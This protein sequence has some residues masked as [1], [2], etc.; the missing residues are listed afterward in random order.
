MRIVDAF[1]EKRNLEVSCKEITFV[2]GDSQSDVENAIR[3][4]E[5][6]YMVVKIP[7]SQPEL[8]FVLPEWGF[9][10]VECIMSMEHNLKNISM[11]R[12]WERLNVDLHYCTMDETDMEVM[13]KEIYE[14]L[15]STDRICVDPHFTK[16]VASNRYVN[17]IKDE[18]KLKCQLYK[19]MFKDK[20]IG[21]FTFKETQP[22]IYFPFLAGLYSAYL[23][24]GLGFSINLKALEEAKARNGKKVYG[25]IST[26]NAAIIKIQYTLGYSITNMHYV[27]V[28]HRK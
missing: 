7:T 5:A 8:T 3:D 15:F 9:S 10:F 14:G 27:Y 20:N 2:L 17:W 25:F 28:K 24:S 18:M 1:W 23:N 22:G 19:I 13:F 6:E 11:T 12:I 21:F 26:N 4:N 16:E